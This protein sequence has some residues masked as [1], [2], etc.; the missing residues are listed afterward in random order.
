MVRFAT[1]LLAILVF[2]DTALAE[3]TPRASSLDRRVR[4]AR[5]VDGQVFN[6]IVSLTR[7]TTVEFEAGEQIVSIVAG[8]TDSFK[9]EGIPGGRVFAIKPTA[10]GEETNLTV[11]TNQRSYY[12]HLAEGRA[13]FYVLRFDYPRR[14]QDASRRA[15][16]GRWNDSY[17]VSARREITPMTVWDNG[18][19][20]YFRFSPSAPIPAIFK[21]T[22]NTERSVNSV[23]L[24]GNV[25]RVSG[26]SRQWALRLGEQEVCIVEMTNG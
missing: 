25:M 17:G 21:V 15:K 14:Q 9:F 24:Q 18:T 20:T 26:T 11:Y 12:F 16:A 3:S 10:Q 19:Y 13:P 8:D 6:I 7:A 5:Y 22:G 2:A 1:A 4:M 23:R